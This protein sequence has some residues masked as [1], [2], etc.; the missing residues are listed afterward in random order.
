M[1]AR[2]EEIAEMTSED[3]YRTSRRGFGPFQSA[4]D[5]YVAVRSKERRWFFPGRIENRG[6][7]SLP[8]TTREP[9]YVPRPGEQR[10]RGDAR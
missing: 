7:T 1:D 10:R 4:L 5:E 2:T 6:K 8:F 3:L 9:D